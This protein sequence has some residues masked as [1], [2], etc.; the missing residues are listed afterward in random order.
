MRWDDL[1]DDLQG[2]GA[3]AVAA[4]VAGE[5]A[6]RGRYEA[7]RTS[8]ADRLRAWPRGSPLS[9]GLAHGRR[10]TGTPLA[11]GLD[12]MVLLD[13]MQE[14]LVPLSAIHWAKP[15]TGDRRVDPAPIARRGGA[16]GCL[17]HR[18]SLAHAIRYLARDRA[19]VQVA[20]VDGECVSG[21]ADK[22]ALDHFE[23]AQHAPDEPRRATS[24][25]GS[26]VIPYAAVAVVRGGQ[27][28]SAS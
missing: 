16:A 9:V 22:A 10:L 2:Q 6:D 14:C 26:W 5:V 28:W 4:E 17:L 8:L 24:V 23:L 15:L 7:G 18:L 3:A 11:V 21:T 27:V 20:L 19:L 25:R 1:F 13:G 12:W